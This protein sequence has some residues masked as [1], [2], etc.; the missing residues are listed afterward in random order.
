[1]LKR[2]E[3]GDG[4]STIPRDRSLALRSSGSS[5]SG[6]E[7]VPCAHIVGRGEEW[8]EETEGRREGVR[9]RVGRGV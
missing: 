9:E 7:Q 8:G 3:E 6:P 4:N 5:Y 2:G 1:M